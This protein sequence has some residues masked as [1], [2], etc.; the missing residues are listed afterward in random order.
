M[1][2]YAIRS[3]LATHTRP[4]TCAEAGCLAYYQGWT[5][6][7]EDLTPELLYTA[8][9]SGRRFTTEHVAE[10]ETYLVFEAGQL[11]FAAGTHRVPTGKPEI[12]L[13]GRG[14]HRL[15][16]PRRAKRHTSPEDFMDDLHTH[17]DKVHTDRERK[18]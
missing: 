18:L 11:C 7:V 17:L 13:V 12:Y 9:H 8:K 2:T 1:K 3:P 10:G 4:A 14:D 16:D 5:L 6:R 15:F